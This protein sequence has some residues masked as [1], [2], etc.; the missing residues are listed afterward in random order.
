M[1]LAVGAGPVALASRE[2]LLENFGLNSA[3]IYR[4]VR[5]VVKDRQASLS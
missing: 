1:T 2:E 4:Q 5:A 3:G